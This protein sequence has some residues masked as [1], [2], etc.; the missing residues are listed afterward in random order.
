MKVEQFYC[1]KCNTITET[2]YIP[3]IID[4]PEC[5]AA[6]VLCKECFDSYNKDL[7]YLT[8]KHEFNLD[9]YIILRGGS[10]GPFLK[11]LPNGSNMSEYLRSRKV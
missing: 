5:G 2:F 6:I 4:H 3:Q 7:Y 10:L 1:E 11:D 9:Q 8:K